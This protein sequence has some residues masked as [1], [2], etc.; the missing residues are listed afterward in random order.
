MYSNSPRLHPCVWGKTYTRSTRKQ[1]EDIFIFII[2]REK[3]GQTQIELMLWLNKINGH[4]CQHSRKFSF[5]I[6][7]RA[8][9]TEIIDTL[10]IHGAKG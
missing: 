8:Q 6:V 10:S 3:V 4:L 7:D 5:E 9:A 1:P 2:E